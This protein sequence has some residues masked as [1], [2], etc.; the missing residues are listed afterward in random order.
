MITILIGKKAVLLPTPTIA[1]DPI[2]EIAHRKFRYHLSSE[3]FVAAVGQANVHKS[4]SLCGDSARQREHD[5]HYC[6]L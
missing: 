3:A 2:S 6:D 4:T 1:I 5:R